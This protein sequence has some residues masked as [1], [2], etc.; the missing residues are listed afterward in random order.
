[1]WEK[2]QEGGNWRWCP[3]INLGGIKQSIPTKKTTKRNNKGRLYTTSY[4]LELNQIYVPMVNNCIPQMHQVRR[5]RLP[6]PPPK[7]SCK[8]LSRPNNLTD[9]WPWSSEYDEYLDIS[10]RF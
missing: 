1:M 6:F 3:R 5:R 4:I 10:V 7:R 2:Y 9:D 8:D